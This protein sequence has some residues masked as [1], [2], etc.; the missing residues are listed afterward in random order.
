MRCTHLLLNVV[1]RVR[2]V[3]G[4]A[5]QDDMRVGV[6]ERTETIIVLLSSRI[7]QGKLN[8]LSIDLNI[9]HIILEHS[10]NID[11]FGGTSDG[12]PNAPVLRAVFTESTIYA[13][14]ENPLGPD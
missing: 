13:L 4:E 12:D 1:Q 14:P 11:L 6:A 9:G 8:V 3:N 7:P 5:D 10:G 2:G